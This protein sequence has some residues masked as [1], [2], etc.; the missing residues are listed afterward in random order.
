MSK[1]VWT[2]FKTPRIVYKRYDGITHK[3]GHGYM[4]L[5][6]GKKLGRDD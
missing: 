3:Y 4:P 6:M 5:S 1:S 2:R